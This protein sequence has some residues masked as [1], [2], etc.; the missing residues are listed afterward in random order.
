[1][2]CL[3]SVLLFVCPLQ[4]V[5]QKLYIYPTEATAPR[6]SYQTVTVVVNGVNDKTVTWSTSGGQIV[7]GNP[8][9]VNEPCTIAL[10]SKEA[11]TFHLKATSNANHSVAAESALTFA[12]TQTHVTSH[13]RLIVTAWMVPV[14][15]LRSRLRRSDP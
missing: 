13:T 6:G 10:Y 15:R 2:K 3:F 12:A 5:A 1:M 8:C 11:G 4:M 9:A 7:G 14:L